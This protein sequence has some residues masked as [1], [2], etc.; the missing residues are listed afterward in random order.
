[1]HFFQPHRSRRRTSHLT[2][3]ICSSSAAN[4]SHSPALMNYLPHLLSQ[5][6]ALMNYLPHLFSLTGRQIAVVNSSY[7][8]RNSTSAQIRVAHA[9]THTHTHTQTHTHSHSRHTDQ[10]LSSVSHTKRARSD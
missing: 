3:I 6:A 5:S 4:H 8:Q 9:H 10:S 2:S 7:Y 1:T